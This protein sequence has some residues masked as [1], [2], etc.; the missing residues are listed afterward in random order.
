MYSC[1]SLL[2]FSPLV[3]WK[4]LGSLSSGTLYLRLLGQT[5][6]TTKLAMVHYTCWL[7]PV[8]STNL[9][10]P[11]ATRGL[12]PC[13]P[14]RLLSNSSSRRKEPSLFWASRTFRSDEVQEP[15][16]HQ[17]CDVNVGSQFP[18]IR[19]DVGFEVLNVDS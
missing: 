5:C 14:H 1:L 17:M 16:I 11:H 10:A 12:D 7:Q 4:P 19:G 13:Q 18:R 3:D 15:G 2:A 8:H 9:R 6:D